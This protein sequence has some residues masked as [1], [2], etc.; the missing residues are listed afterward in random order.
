MHYYEDG[1]VQL[2]SHKDVQDSVT[3]SVSVECLCFSF[4]FNTDLSID[5]ATRNSVFFPNTLI[6][7][8]YESI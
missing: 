4:F 6:L 3:V 7:A 2:V 8:A 1:N 5:S